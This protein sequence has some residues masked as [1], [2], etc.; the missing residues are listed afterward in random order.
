MTWTERQGLAL[1]SA[2]ITRRLTQVDLAELL[3]I[4]ERSLRRIE[5]GRITPKPDVVD[6][7]QRLCRCTI[8][9]VLLLEPACS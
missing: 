3:G 5:R 1:R 2:R 6:S 9:L 7:W 4:S 8:E